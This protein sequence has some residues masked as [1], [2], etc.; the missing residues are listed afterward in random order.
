MK[1]GEIAYF[2]KCFIHGGDNNHAM[3]LYYNADYRIHYKCRTHSCEKHFGTSLLSM[4]R[5]GLSN[6]KY[7]WKIP[8]DKEVSFNETIEFLINRYKIPF[9][10][11]KGT[12]SSGYNNHEFV[13]VSRHFSEERQKGTISRDFYRSKVEIPSKYFLQRG[14]SIEILDDYDIGECHTYNKPMF[15]RAVVPVYDENGEGIVGFTG[16]SI[17]D[18]CPK[19]SE[20][21]NPVKSC[22]SFPKWMN[23]KGFSKEKSLYNYWKAKKFIEESGVA[24]LVES[25]GNV[26]RLEEANI[27]I[28][29][30]LFGTSLNPPQK[31]LLDMTGALTVLIIM[32]NDEAGHTAALKI[33][34]QLE[35]TYRVFIINISNLDVGEMNNNEITEDIKPWIDR[36]ME[37]Y[38]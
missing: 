35:R 26:W 5:G 34:E 18:K 12:A 38:K 7:G 33:K 8:G 30:G 24:I 6:I 16:R 32:D 9:T 17:F 4:I 29:L 23:N 19:C 3:N 15:N 20:Y 14:Y 27:K 22:H 10:S 31:S 36:A 37:I 2:S 25:P 13:K 1:K 21:H 11:L 28:S